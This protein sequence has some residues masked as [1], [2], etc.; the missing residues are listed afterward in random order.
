MTTTA[1]LIK[2]FDSI[3]TDSKIIM[4]EF[5]K[6]LYKNIFFRNKEYLVENSKEKDFN[7]H[8]WDKNPQKFCL[9]EYD[10]PLIFP[11][12]LLVNDIRS[13]FEFTR[14]K[15][16]SKIITPTRIAIINILI[17]PRV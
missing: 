1:N 12:I 10:N 13:I 11:I 8:V 4:Y 16:N 17:M 2:E 7:K 9:E 6:P 15:M 14:E 5:A 3:T